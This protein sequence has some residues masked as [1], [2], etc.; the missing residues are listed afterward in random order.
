MDWVWSSAIM[1]FRGQH[2]SW[3]DILEVEGLARWLRVQLARVVVVLGR[4]PSVRVITTVADEY[5]AVQRL[6]F[7]DPESVARARQRDICA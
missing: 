1:V 3:N 7:V 6:L 5:T 2:P 4:G